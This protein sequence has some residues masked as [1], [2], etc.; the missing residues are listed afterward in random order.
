M[1]QEILNRRMP[2][3][4]YGWCERGYKFSP[5]SIV[6]MRLN[7]IIRIILAFENCKLKNII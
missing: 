6:K 3:G 2:N 5:Y 4:T 7:K 1:I